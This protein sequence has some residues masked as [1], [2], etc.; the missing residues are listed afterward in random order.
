MTED[1]GLQRQRIIAEAPVEHHPQRVRCQLGQHPHPQPQQRPGSRPLQV[2]MLLQLVNH[3]LQQPPRPHKQP[4]EC[5]RVLDLLVPSLRGEDQV[6][7]KLLPVRLPLLVDEALVAQNHQVTGGVKYTLYRR[8]IIGV[9]GNQVEGRD[10]PV[11]G[12]QQGQ[13]EARVVLLLAGAV[14][15]GGLPQEERSSAEAAQLHHRHGGGIQQAVAL[16]EGPQFLQRLAANELQGP[17]QGA[18]PPVEL[19]L[20]EQPGEEVAK[21]PRGEA[22]KGP[23]GVEA[24]KLLSQSQGKHLAVREVRV[25][26]RLLPK[27]GETAQLVQVVHNHVQCDQEGVQLEVVHVYHLDKHTP[28]R[29]LRYMGNTHGIISND[30]NLP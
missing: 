13:L 27:K 1:Q 5:G 18:H 7:A 11:Q 21:I 20:I 19:G 6:A 30:T 28:L 9:G 26:A 15:H 16:E 8:P 24:Q 29:R 14:A 25:R 2:E 10:H 23:F 4:V 3:R 17:R 12:G 22:Q